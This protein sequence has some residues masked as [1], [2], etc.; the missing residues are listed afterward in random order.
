MNEQLG[1]G[2]QV[3]ERVRLA[4]RLDEVQRQQSKQKAEQTWRQ[5]TADEVSDGI[6]L[7]LRWHNMTLDSIV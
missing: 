6:G 7:H 1:V 3:H 4:V 5:R 2:L